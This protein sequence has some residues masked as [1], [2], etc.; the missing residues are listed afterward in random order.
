MTWQLNN[1][2]ARGM[3]TSVSML[4]EQEVRN[5]HLTNSSV[6]ANAMEDTSRSK[7]RFLPSIC[8]HISCQELQ[9]GN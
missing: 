1:K 2:K 5:L 3:S 4:H 6:A 7:A 9:I 8:F